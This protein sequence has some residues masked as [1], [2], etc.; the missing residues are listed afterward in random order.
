MRRLQTRSL[1]CSIAHKAVINDLSLDFG[2]GEVWGILGRNGVGKTTLLHT[3]AGLRET[4]SG[5]ILLNGHDI[6]Q[7]SRKA[8]AQQVG[9]LLQQHDDIFPASVLENFP[10]IRWSDQTL[11]LERDYLSAP[12]GVLFGIVGSGG[13]VELSVREGSAAKQFGIEPGQRVTCRRLSTK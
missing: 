2:A 9:L 8:I 13:D 1:Y 7:L 6:D 10:E 3:F 11:P 12:A 4:D 5:S